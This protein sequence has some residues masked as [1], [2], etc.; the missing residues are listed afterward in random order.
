MINN[1]YSI[2]KKIGEGRSSVYLC[3]D[4]FV[5]GRYYA[6]KALEPGVPA[7]EAAA[8]RQEYYTVSAMNHPN[9]I[10]AAACGTVLHTD[11]GEFEKYGIATGSEFIVFEYFHGRDL[12]STELVK[13]EESFRRILTQLASALF[14]LHQSGY[15]HNDIKP[16]NILVD[17]ELN[18]K[19]IDMAFCSRQDD[20]QQSCVN[21]TIHYLAPEILSKEKC[22]HRKDLYA[23]GVVLYRM[24]YGV[25]PFDGDNENEIIQAALTRPLRFPRNTHAPEIMTELIKK[26]LARSPENRLSSA[27]D[28]CSLMGIEVTPEMKE[29]FTPVGTFFESREY[30]YLKNLLLDRK[31]YDVILLTGTDGSG[32]TCLLRQLNRELS[33]TVHI[34]AS[35]ELIWGK[36]LLNQI[37]FNRSVY[38]RTG[39][40]L[41]AEVMAFLRDP[42]FSYPRFKKLLISLCSTADF[43]L[44]M[45]DTDQYDSHTREILSDIILIMQSRRIKILISEKGPVR[46]EQYFIRNT[47][48]VKISP[49]NADELT[50]FLRNSFESAFPVSELAEMLSGYIELFPGNI[51]N[52]IRSLYYYGGI[53]IR[54]GKAGISEEP[55]LRLKL[56]DWQKIAF[57]KNFQRMREEEKKALGFLSLFEKNIPADVLQ[58]LMGIPEYAL[59]KIISELDIYSLI[60]PQVVN[61][62]LKIING[63]LQQ[64]IYSTVESTEKLHLYAAETIAGNFPGFDRY[65]LARQFELA[66]HYDKSFDIL[67]DEAGAAEEMLSLKYCGLLL[68]K[69]SAFPVSKEKKLRAKVHLCS[70]LHKTGEIAECLRLSSEISQE[71]DGSSING[72]IAPVLEGIC[73]IDSGE[74]R[75]AIKKLQEMKG[76]P[77]F[78]DK[79]RLIM[80]NIAYAQFDLGGYEE[81]G[82][83]CREL[84]DKPPEECDEIYAKAFNLLG[85]LELFV[86]NDTEEAVNYFTRTL[87]EFRKANLPMQAAAAE[88]NIGNVYNMQSDYLRAEEHWKRALSI[89][90]SVGN[91]D[92]EARILLNYGILHFENSQP[93]LALQKYL[94]ASHIFS[95]LGNPTGEALALTNLGEVYLQTAHYQKSEESLIKAIGIFRETGNV[96]E[97]IEASFIRCKLWFIIG[98]PETLSRL[99]RSFCRL[100]E[101][102]DLGNTKYKSYMLLAGQMHRYLTEPQNCNT[103]ELA[104]IG[105]DFIEAGDKPNF[106]YAAVILAHLL[107]AQTRWKEALEVLNDSRFI[108]LTKNNY[109]SQAISNFLQGVIYQNYCSSIDKNPFEYLHTAFELLQECS[110]SEVSWIVLVG[111][112]D[113]YYQRGNRHKAM[114]YAQYA[115]ELLSKI[116]GEMSSEEMRDRYLNAPARKRALH[117]LEKIQGP[118]LCQ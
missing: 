68:K 14:Y 113:S 24:I 54:D 37:F 64:L 99:S 5:N 61:S 12:L 23:L 101:E 10:K 40:K 71:S 106:I 11:E 79:Q 118:Q 114:N 49:L 33:E 18:L 7:S 76:R 36:L 77:G 72:S 22:D 31:Q 16:D 90:L 3:A 104:E 47:A 9:I 87:E 41:A 48:Q 58:Q 63:S 62:T 108:E 44:L 92:Q 46:P 109:F 110:I 102:C 111:L 26:L 82:I 107:I 56:K 95:C 59:Q 85:L 78:E 4:R 57:Q 66:G 89:N 20:G 80:L 97:E 15:V 103:S 81:A 60:L 45:D 38:M 1:R 53:E 32:K 117:M 50:E 75:K 67:W 55:E 83:I 116:I 17:E 115:N 28:I 105:N 43:V 13:D 35:Q 73:L 21:G 19:L 100:V 6:F 25:F 70:I 96:A 88:V 65:E 39:Q 93:E 74:P 94:D 51:I 98:C 27:L 84:I 52:T 42:S 86:N 91:L 29:V 69:I 8:F 34:A 2:L 30:S 112:A